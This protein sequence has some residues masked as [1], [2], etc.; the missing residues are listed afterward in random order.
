[1]RSA[2]VTILSSLL[3]ALSGATPFAFSDE[4][5]RSHQTFRVHVPAEIRIVTTDRDSNGC[6]QALRISTGMDVS[7][8]FHRKFDA[9]VTSAYV[10]RD[11]Q[12]VTV[13]LS[14]ALDDRNSHTVP[15]L[16]ILPGW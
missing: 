13:P 2:A 12:S 11:G 1:M 4:P 6:P 5:L 14:Q 3:T 16:T 15:Q 9:P 7:V 10:I 8:L